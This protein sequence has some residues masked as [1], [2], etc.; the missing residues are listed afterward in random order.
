MCLCYYLAMFIKKY[1][2]SILALLVVAVMIVEAVVVAR[3]KEAFVVHEYH[4]I[5][6]G[7]VAQPYEK[8][9]D[10]LL[11]R[12]KSDDL[13]A[14]GRALERAEER[15]HEMSHVWLNDDTPDAYRASVIEIL[16]LIAEQDSAHQPATR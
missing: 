16:K 12:Y 1:I 13:D 7:K 3:L 15:K 10:E 11:L 14:L 8:L 4:G 9:V 6:N 2:L 5:L